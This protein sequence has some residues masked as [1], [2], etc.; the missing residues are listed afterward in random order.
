ML[1]IIFINHNQHKELLNGSWI[2]KEIDIE[3][4]LNGIEKTEL[5]KKQYLNIIDAKIYIK[6]SFLCEEC[7]Q[8]IKVTN[9]ETVFNNI[10]NSTPLY[11]NQ[12]FDEK[13]QILFTNVKEMLN[14]TLIYWK[15]AP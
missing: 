2:Y 7:H 10:L 9:V 3:S 4:K 12:S 11:S 6:L 13:K 8:S 5:V 14:N 1:E 15:Q